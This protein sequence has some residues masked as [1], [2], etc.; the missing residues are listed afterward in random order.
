MRALVIPPVGL[1]D[2]GWVTFLPG[3][4]A[5]SKCL[6]ARS[7]QSSLSRSAASTCS[8]LYWGRAVRIASTQCVR[9]RVLLVIVMDDGGGRGFRLVFRR[10]AR[11]AMGA[12]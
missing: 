11:R 1:G 10:R 12:V 4:S 7:G 9:S 8:I 5:P 3:T 2:V 6:T